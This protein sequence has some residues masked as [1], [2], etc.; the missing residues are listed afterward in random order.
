MTS[1]TETHDRIREA[2]AAASARR[3]VDDGKIELFWLEFTGEN[4]GDL[5]TCIVPAERDDFVGAVRC[6]HSLR[7]NPGGNVAW[8]EGRVLNACPAACLPGFS[9]ATKLQKPT[10]IITGGMQ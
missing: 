3:L 10:S 9:A 7:C 2:K 4:G 5:G 6:A 8:M 1:H